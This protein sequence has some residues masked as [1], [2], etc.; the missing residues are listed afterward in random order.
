MILW[1]HPVSP[2]KQ[3]SRRYF[4][5]S[6][7]WIMIL[8]APDLGDGVLAAYWIGCCLYCWLKLVKTSQLFC[9]FIHLSVCLSDV[10]ICV[11]IYDELIIK[12][13]TKNSHCTKTPLQL[14]TEMVHKIACYSDSQKCRVLLVSAIVPVLFLCQMLLSWCLDMVCNEG[15]FSLSSISRY[16][17]LLVLFCNLMDTLILRVR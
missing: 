14:V 10:P 6:F 12:G 7:C 11:S 4:T 15:C 9:L 13:N 2:C 5:G 16:I 8:R 17:V 3:I 1:A